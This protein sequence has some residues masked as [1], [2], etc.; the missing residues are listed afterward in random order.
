M[1]KFVFCWLF[2]LA[3]PVFAQ[4]YHPVA[5]FGTPTAGTC[6]TSP[7]IVAGSTDGA[8][9]I[10][11]G[12]G[13]V[14]NC[15]VNFSATLSATPTCVITTNSTTTVPAITTLTTSVLT[16]GLSVSLPSGKISWICFLK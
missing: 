10:N 9:S 1:R 15:A 16:V 7:S 4:Q 8:G 6:G 3:L 11:I 2:F 13:V 5:S 14:T 12:T